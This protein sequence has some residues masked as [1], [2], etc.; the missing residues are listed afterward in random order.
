MN[1]I[2]PLTFLILHYVQLNDIVELPH[3]S[4]TVHYSKSKNYPVKVEWW[5]TK[6]MLSCV[7]KVPRTDKF[8]Q[9][10]LFVAGT[11]LQDSYTGSGFDRG[12]NY[13][14][15]DAACDPI[16][17]RE[18]FYF[19]NMTA[20]FPSLNR[21]DWKSL[22][23]YTR[24]LALEKDSIRVICG[25]SGVLKKIGTVSVPLSCWKIIYIKKE[26]RVIAFI[27]S[28]DQSR[29]DGFENNKVPIEAVKALAEI[30]IDL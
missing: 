30:R 1:F 3:K 11:N 25:S 26:K 23:E 8:V 7:K 6:Q 27:F 2:L 17:M 14:A 4:Y 22:E 20:Q 29:P 12:H 10:P 18:S 24:N 15:A 5:I 21:G 19:S 16:S 9:D 13:N 28:N